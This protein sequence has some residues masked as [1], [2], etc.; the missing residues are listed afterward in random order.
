MT[1]AAPGSPAALTPREKLIA[2]T[3]GTPLPALAAAL[4][5]LDAKGKLDEAELLVRA[6]IIDSICERCPAAEA[7]FD[8]WAESDDE[9]PRTATLA[10]A[11][12]ATAA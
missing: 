2:R 4:L 11:A 9:D 7:A 1:S 5:M 8:A 12:A 10:M 3:N 6:T